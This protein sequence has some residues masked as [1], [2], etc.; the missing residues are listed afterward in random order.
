MASRLTVVGLGPG[1]PE[2]IT[3]K[4]QRAIAAADLVFAPRS[5]DSAGSLALRI[6]Q[7]WIDPER[8]EVVELAL[9]MTRDPAQLVPAWERAA[10]QIGALLE[11][12]RSGVYLLLGDPLLYGTFSYIQAVLARTHPQIEV[13]IVP[14]VTSFAAAAARTQ[15]VLCAAD[16]RLAI[17]PAPAYTDAAALS[18]V[19]EQCETLVLMKVGPVLPQI[20]E[21]LDTL[22]LL[23]G[24]VYAQQV[25]LPEEKIVRELRELRGQTGPYFSLV[26]V[27]RG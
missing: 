6:A 9:A 14:G 18:G 2:L 20:I 13:A 4:G 16:E 27:K 15:T 11:G 21:A 10:A 19:L 7:P 26:I 23:A 25:G 17:V 24:A 5:R 3:V 1:D 12:G 22:G 8:Q